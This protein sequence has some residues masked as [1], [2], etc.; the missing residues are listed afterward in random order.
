MIYPDDYVNKIICGDCLDVMKGIPDKS[1]DL[2]LTD[3][4]YGTT[5]CKWDAVIPFEPMWMQLK[6]I[7]KEN[8]AI[9]LFGSQPFTSALI[10]SNPK[11]FRY[12]WIWDKNKAANFL[13]G[14]KM[15]MKIT[16]DIVVFYKRQPTYNPQ[17]TKNPKGE[18]KRH[19]YKASL[20][21]DET[22]KQ[23]LPNGMDYTRKSSKYEPGKLLPTTILRFK[24]D[25]KPIHPTQKPVA[26]FEYLIKTYTDEGNTVLDNCIGSG[27]TAIACIN[28][29]RNFIG[30]ELDPKYC[31]IA[32]QRIANV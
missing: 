14:N 19:L 29:N 6:R 24:R 26:L 17:K 12:S 20:Q 5:A 4:P 8:S 30:I 31:E 3:P 28:T 13:F 9:I 16:E 23:H 1:I 15:P 7:T 32:R 25:A 27:T 11:M 2:V 18:E 22:F 10:M 21:K